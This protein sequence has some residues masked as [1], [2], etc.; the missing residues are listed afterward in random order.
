MVFHVNSS[1]DSRNVE[2]IH[3]I[4]NEL[5][6]QLSS[7]CICRCGGVKG[8]SD[9]SAGSKFRILYSNELTRYIVFVIY[10]AVG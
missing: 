3:F 9:Q 8:P 6:M 2:V 1:F 4:F 10:L 5:G 7:R